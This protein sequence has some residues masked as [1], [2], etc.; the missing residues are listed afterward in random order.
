M[1]RKTSFDSAPDPIKK[2]KIWT[3]SEE[4]QEE[5]YSA[6]EFVLPVEMIEKILSYLSVGDMMCFGS[7]CS[8]WRELSVYKSWIKAGILDMRYM[9]TD[10]YRELSRPYIKYEQVGF[11]ASVYVNLDIVEKHLEEINSRERPSILFSLLEEKLDSWISFN[12]D[13]FSDAKSPPIDIHQI[14]SF[15]GL[16]L[17]LK[18]YQKEAISWMIH[19][20]TKMVNEYDL[21]TSMVPWVGSGSDLFFDYVHYKIV[22]SS[23]VSSY[24]KARVSGGILADEMGMGKTIEVLGLIQNNPPPELDCLTENHNFKESVHFPSRA[25]LVV[26][27]SQISKQWAD[28]VNKHSLNDLNVILL[29][30]MNHSK[31][32]TFRDIMEADI[33]IVSVQFLQNK[34]YM[35]LGFTCRGKLQAKHVI[36]RQRDALPKIRKRLR[37]MKDNGLSQDRPILDFF[38]WWRIVYDEGHE[39][40]NN[41]YFKALFR[42]YCSVYSWLVSGTPPKKFDHERIGLVIDKKKILKELTEEEYESHFVATYDKYLVRNFIRNNLLCR[43]MKDT[44]NYEYTLSP[45]EEQPIYLDFHPIERA[46]YHVEYSESDVK[47]YEYYL[48]HVFFLRSSLHVAIKRKYLSISKAVKDGR[49]FLNSF[50]PVAPITLTQH[51]LIEEKKEIL[52]EKKRKREV[53]SLC[54]ESNPTPIEQLKDGTFELDKAICKYGT[55]LAHLIKFILDSYDNEGFRSLVFSQNT[56]LLK[57]ITLLLSHYNISTIELIGNVNVK[58]KAIRDFKDGKERVMLMKLKGNES[59]TNLHNASHVILVDPLTEH[60]KD[61]Q[62]QA[63]GRAHRLGRTGDPVK[64]VRFIIRDTFEEE[65]NKK[66]LL[67][68]DNKA[69]VRTSS[70]SGLNVN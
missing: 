41:D 28:E 50:R 51:L 48:E 20:E 4:S 18:Q 64:V 55:K 9:T 23:D 25:T 33:V 8:Y 49:Y 70:L 1:K 61:N 5:E 66:Y 40:L 36:Q 37:K 21:G 24:L 46:L 27:P 58:K 14:E 53:L 22:P 34:N 12:K 11:Q 32:Y 6:Q 67:E 45:C 63:I 52:L 65:K 26:C 17:H 19:V 10:V 16:G 60:N 2:P 29:E 56:M 54:M 35:S 44:V 39:Y 69:P 62:L 3:T 57:D 30:T 47:P 59:G 7:V 42:G 31:K 68:R 43:H 15:E 38:K 13:C